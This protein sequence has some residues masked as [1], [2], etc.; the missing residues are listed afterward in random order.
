[1]PVSIILY[2]FIWS[3][4]EYEVLDEQRACSFSYFLYYCM[5]LLPADISRYIKWTSGVTTK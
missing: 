1:M 2:P 4:L 3:I 5:K